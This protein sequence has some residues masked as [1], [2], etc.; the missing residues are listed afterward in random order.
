[1]RGELCPL[2]FSNLISALCASVYKIK[3]SEVLTG[4]N[5]VVIFNLDGILT[6]KGEEMGWRDFF[7]EVKEVFSPPKENT[8]RPWFT[9]EGGPV[10]TLAV[11]TGLEL[12]LFSVD[13]GFKTWVFG[14]G[15]Y[16]VFWAPPPSRGGWDPETPWTVVSSRHGFF[17][18]LPKGAGR[19]RKFLRLE[20]VH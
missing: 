9:P 10:G 17:F 1:M 15:E 16:E 12:E 19:L 20:Q 6:E 3:S 14:P 13:N 18:G 5:N 2:N 11:P 7:Q 4:M 8:G